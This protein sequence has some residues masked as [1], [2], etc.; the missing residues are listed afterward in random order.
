MG[1]A[2]PPRRR[3]VQSRTAVGNCL[4]VLLVL[5]I[6]VESSSGNGK[7]ADDGASPPFDFPKVQELCHRAGLASSHKDH[8]LSASL[9]EQAVEIMGRV[10]NVK[11]QERL[12]DAL[13]HGGA[14]ARA[15]E[16]Y[17]RALSIPPHQSGLAPGA[18]FLLASKTANAARL[19]RQCPL[20]ASTL[21]NLAAAA[22]QGGDG[23]TPHPLLLCALAE[24]SLAKE[25]ETPGGG[26]GDF[27]RR[28]LA[29]AVRI[30]REDAAIHSPDM[31]R[32]VTRDEGVL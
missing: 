6:P 11:V 28:V 15:L 10:V 18:H 30:A 8:A 13:A 14:M 21:A 23:E 32:H 16:A 24:C 7:G 5:L 26:E 17:M 1:S 2:P 20:A 9:Y 27:R 22:A 31:H 4:A 19:A 3:G 25:S 12:G 29:A